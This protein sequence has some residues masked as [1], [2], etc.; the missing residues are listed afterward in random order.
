MIGYSKDRRGYRIYDPENKQVIE[1]RSVK[2]N[3]IG[4]GKKFIERNNNKASKYEYDSI[5][6]DDETEIDTDKEE[7]VDE[8]VNVDENI[9]NADDQNEG[10]ST[11]DRKCEYRNTTI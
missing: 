11:T 8:N 3:E 1:E 5:L 7:I 2:F 4:L 9:E 6:L 10:E